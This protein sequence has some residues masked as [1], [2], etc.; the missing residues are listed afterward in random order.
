[1]LSSASKSSKN[2]LESLKFINTAL[3]EL[4]I[5]KSGM[6]FPRQV[7]G[8]HYS[9]VKTTGLRNPKLVGLSKDACALLDVDP[10]VVSQELDILIGNKAPPTSS[11][12]F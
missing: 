8:F 9:T 1:M 12:I 11:V 7:L 3:N 4:R 6:N 2:S 10:D 5:D